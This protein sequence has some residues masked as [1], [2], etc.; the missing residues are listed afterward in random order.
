MIYTISADVF[1]LIS[2]LN[3]IWNSLVYSVIFD[4]EILYQ[5]GVENI[6]LSLKIPRSLRNWINKVRNKVRSGNRFYPPTTEFRTSKP[7]VRS[8]RLSSLL[9]LQ[10]HSRVKTVRV[11]PG[12]LMVPAAAARCA[13]ISTR[14]Y[15]DYSNRQYEE[16]EREDNFINRLQIAWNAFRDS[17]RWSTNYLR[18]WSRFS[19]R[20][21]SKRIF[22]R[23]RV[24]GKRELRARR[25]IAY[26]MKINVDKIVAKGNGLFIRANKSPRYGGSLPFFGVEIRFRK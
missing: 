20:E 8:S 24:N 7:A 15:A 25:A 21:F 2:K 23:A 3:Y 14:K 11:S 9:F 6:L 16:R 13:V 5:I 17:T 12:L 10:G 22:A 26:S 4:L 18:L 19:G 1:R